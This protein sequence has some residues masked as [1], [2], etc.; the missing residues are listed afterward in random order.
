M[1]SSGNKNV[2]GAP[3]SPLVVS[4]V[5]LPIAFLLGACALEPEISEPPP[6]AD[7]AVTL[8]PMR[9]FGGGASAPLTATGER[10]KLGYAAAVAATSGF[11][12]V[13]DSSVSALV[14]LDFASGDSRR[15]QTLDDANTSG[16]YVT[17][18]LIIYVVDRFNRAVLELSE[19][20]WERRVYSDNKLIPA[21]VDVTQTNWGATVLI[22]DELTQRLVMFDTQSNPTRLFTTTLSPVTIAASISAIAATDNFVF[23]LDAASRE[24]TQLDLYGRVVGTFGEDSLLAPVALAVDECRRMFVAD[25][26]PDGLFVSSPDFYGMD[27]RAAVP[28]EIAPAVTDLWIDGNDLYVAAGTFGVHVLAIDPPCMAP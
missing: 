12:F 17:T 15:L 26:H 25:G 5:L 18:D 28:R 23:V 13:I 4:A 7:I 19:S 27:S 20:G 9:E 21:P 14:Q 8:T 24:V 22:A 3:G 10:Q 1:A 6:T 16:M 2:V 11:V